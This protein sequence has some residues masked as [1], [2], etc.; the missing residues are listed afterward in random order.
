MSL[1]HDVSHPPPVRMPAH[2]VVTWR[3]PFVAPRAAPFG[4]ADRRFAA[5]RPW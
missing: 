2:A 3:V 1:P 4:E 5:G